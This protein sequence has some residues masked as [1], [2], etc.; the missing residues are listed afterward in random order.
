MFLVLQSLMY[1]NRTSWD[2]LY[3]PLKVFQKM[4]R[5]S[6]MFIHGIVSKGINLVHKLILC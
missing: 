5:S 3:T 4:N 6:E 2:S 1:K